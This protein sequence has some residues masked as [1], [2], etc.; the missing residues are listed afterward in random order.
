MWEGAFV[1][2]CAYFGVAVGCR[3]RILRL[4][5]L[6]SWSS[7]GCH[8]VYET[9]RRREFDGIGEC[10]GA[11]GGAVVVDCCVMRDFGS[12]SE[13]NMKGSRPVDFVLIVHKGGWRRRRRLF[14]GI[15]WVP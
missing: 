5:V 15:G 7:G 2:E 13:R 3:G 6:E 11:H 9:G 14:D 8:L 10:D 1:A 4:F 12:R